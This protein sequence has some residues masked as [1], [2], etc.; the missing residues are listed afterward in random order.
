STV[1]DYAAFCRFLM[2][3]G[4][5]NGVR[6]LSRETVRAMTSNQVGATFSSEGYGWG[7]GVRV[8]T[9]PAGNG[10]ES[11][12]AF[13][14]NGGTGTL[15]L[16][17]PVKNAVFVIIAPSSPGTPGVSALRNNFVAAGYHILTAAGTLPR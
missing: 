3:G 14:W 2:N 6:L 5:L 12:G 11:T 8:R 4:E 16:A 15:F 7:Y 1:A 10:H 13:G 9:A 17:D